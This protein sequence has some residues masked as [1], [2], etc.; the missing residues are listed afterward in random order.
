VAI[1]AGGVGGHRGQ[2]AGELTAVLL[3]ARGIE[4]KEVTQSEATRLDN[5]Q[6]RRGLL[7]LQ[8]FADLRQDALNTAQGRFPGNG[9]TRRARGRLPA[10]LLER[11]DDP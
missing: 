3:A 9:G 4:P 6:K 7:G 1:L 2:R 5:L 11:V 8:E 10:R